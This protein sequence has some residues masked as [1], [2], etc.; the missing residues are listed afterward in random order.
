MEDSKPYQK[1]LRN[2]NPTLA[3][4]IKKELEK[5][6]VVGIIAPTRHTSWV[7]NPVIVRQKNGEIHICVDFRNLN[8]A[9][10]KDN[11]NL[12]NMDIVLKN[13]TGSGMLCMLDGF[14]GYNQVMVHPNDRSKTTFT[15][16]WGTFQYP[17]V[18]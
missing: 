2:I 8:I 3:P 5:M 4:L 7:S 14:Y 6:L 13:V 17:S 15:T 12:P 1:K 18:F 10:L 9:S 16:P 11:Y